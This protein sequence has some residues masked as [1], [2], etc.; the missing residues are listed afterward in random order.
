MSQ[1][2]LV[3]INLYYPVLVTPFGV[4][5]DYL[6]YLY[7]ASV[8]AI[9]NRLFMFAPDGSYLTTFPPPPPA[10]GLAPPG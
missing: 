4:A 10:T 5:V 7:I 8:N 6:G 9:G 1:N 3:L 2:G